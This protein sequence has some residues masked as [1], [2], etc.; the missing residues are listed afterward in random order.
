M[1]ND[2]IK[3]SEEEYEYLKSINLNL[4]KE[5]GIY[6]DYDL[7]MANIDKTPR[8]IIQMDDTIDR[9]VLSWFDK[10]FA[11]NLQ[12]FY[13]SNYASN[14]SGNK[15]PGN[16]K[17]PLNNKAS[18]EYKDYISLKKIFALSLKTMA[19][20]KTKEMQQAFNNAGNICEIENE[21]AKEY[22]RSVK[23]LI[24]EAYTKPEADYIDIDSRIETYK[25][26]LNDR[27]K[28]K[29]KAGTIF[30]DI[31]D[32]V[33]K[34]L[35]NKEVT[36]DEAEIVDYIADAIG[37]DTIYDVLD[38]KSNCFVANYLDLMFVVRALV[39]SSAKKDYSKVYKQVLSL[40]KDLSQGVEEVMPKGY[41]DTE[42]SK[43]LLE[44]DAYIIG[45]N[46]SN[47]YQEYS[48]YIFNNSQEFGVLNNTKG[49]S[50]EEVSA[51]NKEYFDR[52]DH[53]K[54]LIYHVG[55]GDDTYEYTPKLTE[56][57]VNADKK[58]ISET[59]N[60]LEDDNAKQ[61]I[62]NDLISII[63]KLI[64]K[65]ALKDDERA[66]LTS[67][68]IA[69]NLS[70]DELK[71]KK[72][73]LE[74]TYKE[75]HDAAPARTNKIK[76]LIKASDIIGYKRK[77]G[78]KNDKGINKSTA[79]E[80]WATKIAKVAFPFLGGAVG[81]NLA[82]VL[83][84]VGI[85]A[86]N[87][88][89]LFII[90]QARAYANILEE[91]ELSDDEIE[92]ES[93]EKPTNKV[94]N[95]V[96]SLLRKA[97]LDKIAKFNMF[98]KLSNTRF[99]AV[100]NFFGNKDVLRTIANTI[101][102]GLIAMD[103]GAL[104]NAISKQIAA[105]NQQSN[106]VDNNAKDTGKT[107]TG[108][109]DTGAGN[110]DADVGKTDTGLDGG[111]G[112]GAN[113][114]NAFTDPE[115]ASMKLGDSIGS[116]SQIINGYKTSYDAYNGV[117]SVHLNQDILNDGNTIIKNLFYNDNGK[118]VKLPINPG[119]DIA[120]ALARLGIDSKDVVANLTNASGKGRA[121]AH[122]DDVARTLGRSL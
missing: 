74:G 99:K 28:P 52:K 41:K 44:L 61:A 33:E 85:V 64:A 53:G 81:A 9:R 36:D 29:L 31:M 51:K 71:A 34:R 100:N 110:T 112:A 69:E 42:I 38:P 43:A 68:G 45:M 107:D 23:D 102:T 11:S 49:L 5:A 50:K 35:N 116:D 72:A 21:A 26:V 39:D 79:L 94:C 75:L 84:P 104:K 101:T 20:G 15:A 78:K 37:Y 121:W 86:T 7:I 83:G 103:I 111:T 113:D 70:E 73:E 24:G 57:E 48:Q 77:A 10:L 1:K 108:A 97:H 92:I 95:K 40:K 91:Q 25:Q 60:K 4:T 58:T 63:D 59:R 98:E 80:K 16:E 46:V 17:C 14:F 96:S 115:P 12:S 82:F 19:D 93:I 65:E 6:F 62:T 122:I 109:G 119:E 32:I 27:K 3:L 13:G 30:N 118:M 105:R 120:D 2:I 47:I 55:F 8:E 22:T 89:G 67:N 56:N 76:A 117:N 87:A 114:G 90:T 18:Q 88:I 54:E 106:T 66:L